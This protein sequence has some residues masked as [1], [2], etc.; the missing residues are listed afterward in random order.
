MRFQMYCMFDKMSG[1]YLQPFVARSETDARRTLALGFEDPGFLQSPAGR[2]PQDF[3]MY[4]VGVFEDESG[5]INAVHTPKMVCHLSD[6]RPLP[7]A[8]TVSS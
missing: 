4:H 8:S 6:L 7:P 2:H 5:V 1:V 3:A